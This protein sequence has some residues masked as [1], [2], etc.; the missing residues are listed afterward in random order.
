MYLN[1][2]VLFEKLLVAI[3]KSSESLKWEG[4]VVINFI[5]SDDNSVSILGH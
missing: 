2:Y 5:F 1:T 4:A 3:L